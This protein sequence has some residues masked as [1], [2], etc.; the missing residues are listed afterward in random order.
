MP[1]TAKLPDHTPVTEAARIAGYS[2]HAIRWRVRKGYLSG[3]RDKNGC[4]HIP[5]NEVRDL[6]KRDKYAHFEA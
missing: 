6:I 2:A 4:L 3:T 5:D 1:R